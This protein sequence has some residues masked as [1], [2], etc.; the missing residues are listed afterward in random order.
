MNNN[1]LYKNLGVIKKTF[2]GVTERVLYSTL[3]ANQKRALREAAPYM[4]VY[5]DKRGIP[6]PTPSPATPRSTQDL[7]IPFA[8]KN[9][10]P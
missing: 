5:L 2:R 7:A 6:H 8:N 1:R 9:L 10:K 4:R 3:T